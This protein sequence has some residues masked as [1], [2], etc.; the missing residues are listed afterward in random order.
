VKRQILWALVFVAAACGPM[1]SPGTPTEAGSQQP[2]AASGAASSRTVAPDVD[3]YG[4]LI[5]VPAYSHIYHVRE[6]RDF[7]LT[8]TLSI[9]NPF[10][11]RGLV[12]NRVDYFDSA[13]RFVRTYLDAPR[14][15]E[16]L[17]TLAFVVAEDDET[18]G[19]G[20]NFLVGWEGEDGDAGPITEAVMIGTAAG[21]GLSF[22][23]VGRPVRR[24]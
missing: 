13:G 1:D 22:T 23:S 8:V 9:R 5:Y 18:G 3:A 20:A 4:Q 17:E 24:D 11:W 16:P 15:L 2:V 19:S 12:I 21:Q 10:P 14:T 7:Q 6:G